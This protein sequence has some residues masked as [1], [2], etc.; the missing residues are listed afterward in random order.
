M[1]KQDF[2]NQLKE[3]L[4]M[5][6]VEETSKSIEYYD[7][8]IEDRVEDGM[9]EAEAIAS[10]G[11]IS[12]IVN[13]IKGELPLKTIVKEKT[14]GKKLPV[15]AIVL[16]ILGFPIW[17]SV[18]AVIFSLYISIW[19]IVFSFGCVALSFAVTSLFSFAFVWIRL[20]SGNL[21]DAIFTF[22]VTLIAGS[23]AILFGLI[24]YLS[25]KG[26]VLG[27][28]WCIKQIKMDISGKKEKE[29]K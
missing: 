11:P 12:E 25:G 10:L 6:P 28:K 21:L 23:L 16:I 17:I 8:A 2:L 15:W 24:T 22:G 29:K 7:E 9:T 4:K 19:A 1:N 3:E 13:Q 5:Y 20:F 18:A 26:L 27:T 14:E